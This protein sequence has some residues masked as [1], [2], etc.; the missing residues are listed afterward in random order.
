MHTPVQHSPPVVHTSPCCTQNDDALHTP[1]VQSA[2]QHSLPAIHAL[3]KVLQVVLRGVHLPAAHAPLQHWL[4]E[5]HAALSDVHAGTLHTPP[6]HTPSQQS[7]ALVHLPPMF[8]HIV[9]PVPF[10]AVPPESVPDEPAPAPAVMP[11]PL[12]LV[13]LFSLWEQAT[14]KTTAPNT[15]RSHR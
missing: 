15:P 9:E 8:R 7:V 4:P 2:E 3:P 1:P 6:L 11:A 10:D 12:P 13:E 5:V 14:T